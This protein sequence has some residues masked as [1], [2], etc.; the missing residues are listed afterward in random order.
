MFP[1]TPLATGPY[2]P[3]ALCSHLQDLVAGIGCGRTAALIAQGRPDE[4]EQVEI[5]R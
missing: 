3:T 1:G 4:P 5:L 2:D